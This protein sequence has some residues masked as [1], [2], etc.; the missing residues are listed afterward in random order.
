MRA[1]TF[2][3]DVSASV[4][5]AG[6]S[7]RFL[8]FFAIDENRGRAPKPI[9]LGDLGKWNLHHLQRDVEF[10]VGNT[11]FQEIEKVDGRLTSSER[12]DLDVLHRVAFSD[13]LLGEEN[14]SPVFLPR[15]TIESGK[16]P[17][18]IGVEVPKIVDK[19]RLR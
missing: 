10:V 4:E 19:I 9:F 7:T 16:Q 17:Y 15:S 13:N 6:P 1:E 2:R 5:S 18:V 3:S 11:V 14:N 8:I 12:N